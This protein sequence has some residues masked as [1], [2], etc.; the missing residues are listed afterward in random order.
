[1]TL[2]ALP[3]TADP[4]ARVH[5]DLDDL[6]RVDTDQLT[7][8]EQAAMLESMG[9][10][11]AKFAAIKL[12][13]LASAERGRAAAAA[14]LASTGQWAAQA[15]NADPVVAHRQVQLS[16]RLE[17]RTI[18]QAALAAGRLSAEHAAVIVHADS[19]LPDSVSTAQRA[20]I[21]QALVE[22]AQVMPPTL[23]RRAAR[24]ALAEVEP[25]PV[26]VDAHENELV[27]DEEASARSRTRLSLHDNGDGTVTG[28]FTVPTLHGH[29][30]RKILE[31]ITAPRRGRLGASTA[32]IGGSS[33][34][35]TDWD[36]ARGTAFC[37]IL[38]HLP[39]DHLHP[40]TAATVV[41]TIREETLRGALA[42]AHLDTLV[43]L[44]AGEARRLACNATILPAV[45]G[46]A[47]VPLDLGRSARLFSE[48]QR[49]ALGLRHDTSAAEGCDRPFAWTEIHHL[50]AWAAGG[51]T[52]LDNAIGICHFHHQRIHDPA[53]HHRSGTGGITFH[54]R[55]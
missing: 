21:E 8:C 43:E 48:A 42:V 19:Q 3:I 44:S 1:M 29:L 51:T 31:T 10:A 35:R 25:D 36:Y 47:S 54:P 5:A 37:E 27:A 12:R 14:G 26:V 22:K 16:A 49:T 20:V 30:L 4:V 40:R 32:Q 6:G 23:L 2:Q 9:R 52:G 46:G 24:R 45:L 28:H 41:V 15:T 39:T 7:A 18:T 17:E 53:Y 13:V 38:E 33:T 34:L 11:E 50:Q 55:R